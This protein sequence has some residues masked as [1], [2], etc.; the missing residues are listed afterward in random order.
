MLFIKPLEIGATNETD[1]ILQQS[2]DQDMAAVE[3]LGAKD[4]I[5]S[6]SHN[7]VRFYI[8]W[9]TQ[10]F[11]RKGLNI[12]NGFLL[13]SQLDAFETSIVLKSPSLHPTRVD[14]GLNSLVSASIAKAPSISAQQSIG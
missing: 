11:G 12:L 13:S 1:V 7:L 6:P 4:A 9:E 8:P 10:P 5:W 14:F 2:I 3:V